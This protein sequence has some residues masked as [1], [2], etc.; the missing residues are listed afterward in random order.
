MISVNELNSVLTDMKSV[1]N[2]DDETASIKIVRAINTVTDSYNDVV[3]VTTKDTD[4]GI[5]ICLSKMVT[6]EQSGG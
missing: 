5:D 6:E 4:T 2:Y 3:S 1:Y